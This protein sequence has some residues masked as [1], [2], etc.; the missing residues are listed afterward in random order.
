MLLTT[1]EDF[2]EITIGTPP[3]TFQVNL[4]TGSSNM[5]IPSLACRSIACFLHATYDSSASSTHKQNGSEVEINDIS[6]ILS[7]FISDDI[8]QMGH[9]KVKQQD[10]VEVTKLPGLATTYNRFDGVIGLGYDSASANHIV[11][12]FYNMINQGLLDRPVVSFYLSD[13]RNGEEDQSEVTFGGVNE[14]HYTGSMI[15]IPVRGKTY[16]EVD[17]NAIALGDEVAE[18]SNTGVI[19]DPGTALITLPADLAESL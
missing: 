18:L 17:F 10:F 12:P 19:I 3:Q 6:G 15:K 7:G 16:W 2:A 1:L 14:Q 5:W 9:L 8:L 13:T 11:P 4:D